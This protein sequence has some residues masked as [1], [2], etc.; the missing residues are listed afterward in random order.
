ME[1]SSLPQGSLSESHA[2]QVMG[3]SFSPHLHLIVLQ[4]QLNTGRMGRLPHCHLNLVVSETRPRK[5]KA[6]DLTPPVPVLGAAH[7]LV[8]CSQHTPFLLSSA[9]WELQK[10]VQTFSFQ[11][12]LRGWEEL[13]SLIQPVP[14]N[15][16]LCTERNQMCVCQCPY[17]VAQSLTMTLLI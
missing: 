17:Q 16:L 1:W 15:Y 2:V 5:P 11:W 9:S 10:G 3:A 4:E 14:I 7:R 13:G 6:Q 8:F 12:C